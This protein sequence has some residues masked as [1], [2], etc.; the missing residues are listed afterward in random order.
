MVRFRYSVDVI[1]KYVWFLILIGIRFQQDVIKTE[2]EE[3][4]LRRIAAPP[5]GTERISVIKSIPTMRSYGHPIVYI[6][7]Q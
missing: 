7:H 2:A 1:E 6:N 5:C 4:Q 3:L